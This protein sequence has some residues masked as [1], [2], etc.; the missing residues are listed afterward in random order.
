MNKFYTYKDG[1]KNFINKYSENFL[2]GHG[3]HHKTLIKNFY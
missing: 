3:I 1:K 2:Q